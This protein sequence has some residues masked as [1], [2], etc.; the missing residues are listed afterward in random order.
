MYYLKVI[1]LFKKILNIIFE[2]FY[3]RLIQ[4]FLITKFIVFK[5]RDNGA[6]H[7]LNRRLIVSLTSYEKR[8]QYLYFS[9][10]S[11]KNQKIQP[12]YIVIWVSENDLKKIPSK[13]L[14]LKND[15]IKIKQCSELGSYKK[16]INSLIK[17]PNDYIVTADDDIF[18]RNDWLSTLVNCF[19]NDQ[20][21]IVCN[22]AHRIKLS[23]D[24]KILKYN[25]WEHEVFDIKKSRS[26]FPTSGGGT[27]Y[28]PNSLHKDVFKREIFLKNAP[29]ADDI[30][31]YYMALMNESYFT[32]TPYNK[33]LLY[34]PGS[35]KQSLRYENTVLNG[36]DIKIKNLNRIYKIFKT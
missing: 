11:I 19:S 8:F 16:L 28:P 25:K 32:V 22:R 2:N 30:W 33:K 27:L 4:I 18:Y 24:E 14:K 7:K 3:L 9:I 10:L 12:D 20:K 34:W 17:F 26:I 13:I 21:E 31:W 5:S 23:F 29:N 15:K 1:K 35:Q 6:S 36:N